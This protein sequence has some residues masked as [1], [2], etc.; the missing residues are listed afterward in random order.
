MGFKVDT[1]F[2]KFLTM[3]ALGARK[4]IGELSGMGYAPIE[5][6]RYCTSNK[7]WATK[8]KRLRLPDLLCVRT[9]TRFEVRAKSDLKIRMSDAPNNPDRTWD[10][11]LRDHDII[12]LIA[13][14]DNNGMPVPADGAV[15]FTV[16]TLRASVGTSK[17]G[18][19]KSAS[20]GAERD[21]TWPA[22][23]PSRPGE[24]LLVNGGKL[25]VSM[26]GDGN[27]PRR[28]TY[29]LSGKVP[30]V[31]PGERFEAGSDMLAGTPAQLADL[32]GPL[33]NAYN[34]LPGLASAN[35]VDRFSAAKAILHRP[36]LHAAAL[37]ALEDLLDHEG[38]LRVA[39]E[40]AGTATALGS[41]KGQD[42]VAAT[43][44]SDDNKQ[45]SM[46]AIFI[47]TEVKGQFARDRLNAVAGS[48]EF[49]GDE[50]RQ[51]AIWGLGKAGLK[52]YADLVPF[53]ADPEENMAYHAI[54]GFGGDTP[55]VVI[56][57]LITMLVGGHEVAAPAAS[58]ALLVIGSE[59]AL[60]RLLVA[61]KTVN[62]GRDWILATIG[63]FPPQ[64][65][66]AML[67]GLPLLDQLAPM[68]LVAEGANWMS[69]GEAQ[70][71]L[72]FLL[73]QSL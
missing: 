63:R 51:A 25:V 31:T 2:L 66:R 27:P 69:R 12:A 11:G 59:N 23:V 49:Q 8:V 64:M 46:E 48:A 50:R 57:A 3:G 7:I 47:L 6:E 68:L 58:E 40:A 21:R 43:L 15:Y 38:E 22:I 61:A 70:N 4:V 20:E 60:A 52:A 54:S 18:P 13:C 56:D 28:Q 41:A 45:L 71:D 26:E 39:L 34:P 35:D 73:K 32:Q 67:A 5:L 44:H 55:D 19:A 36:D 24:V 42:F 53:V 17:L 30:Y 65:V 33:A 9:G 14:T 29:T 10:A 72:R 62:D 1:S 37:P 16:D